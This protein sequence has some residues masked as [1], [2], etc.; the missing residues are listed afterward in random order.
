MGL[1]ILGVRLRPGKL[2]HISTHFLWDL[3][4]QLS[5]HVSPFKLW[6]THFDGCSDCLPPRKL[7][8]WLIRNKFAWPTKSFSSDISVFS[9]PRPV[10]VEKATNYFYKCLQPKFCLFTICTACS[11]PYLVI[12]ELANRR[13]AHHLHCRRQVLGAHVRVL[14]F[15]ISRPAGYCCHLLHKLHRLLQHVSLFVDSEYR[16]LYPNEAFPLTWLYK[17][18]ACKLEYACVFI[19]FHSVASEVKFFYQV[20]CHQS[21]IC[22]LCVCEEVLLWSGLQVRPQY[23]QP[24][25][26]TGMVHN[27]LSC[28]TTEWDLVKNFV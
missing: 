13:R 20:L 4:P 12:Y 6:Y 22:V 8:K 3:P 9:F 2:F 1:L 15:V 28:Q 21:Y 18:L 17:N 14:E 23:S 26:A 16:W 7:S 11:C 27:R 19:H 25:G 10:A 5:L 24:E